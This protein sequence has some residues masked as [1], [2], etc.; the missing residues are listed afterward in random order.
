MHESEALVVKNCKTSPS[1]SRVCQI[2]AIVLFAF[3]T[4]GGNASVEDS[5]DN[6]RGHQSDDDQLAHFALDAGERFRVSPNPFSGGT[7]PLWYDKVLESSQFIP[8]SGTVLNENEIVKV[9]NTESDADTGE[10][11]YAKD[12]KSLYY[13][14]DKKV[15][16][17]VIV[18]PE[19]D[20]NS[21]WLGKIDRRGARATFTVNVRKDKRFMKTDK[22]CLLCVVDLAKKK[23][24]CA[25]FSI[26]LRDFKS[27]PD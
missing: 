5:Q 16:A 23:V 19:V 26:M 18:S 3:W 11:Y 17:I 27:Q 10:L 13:R 9:T 1:R 4:S 7:F 15:Y 25:I 24:E 6:R 20:L 12:R 14:V 22:R 21:A 8:L 2:I